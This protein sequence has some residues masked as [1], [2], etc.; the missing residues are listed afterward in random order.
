LS[1]V[2]D[3]DIR[4]MRVMLEDFAGSTLHPVGLNLFVDT[5]RTNR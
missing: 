3:G 4:V 5:P 2:D 1:N